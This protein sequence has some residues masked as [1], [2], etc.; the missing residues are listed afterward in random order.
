VD[1]MSTNVSRK[2]LRAMI[3]QRLKPRMK[4]ATVELSNSIVKKLGIGEIERTD[5]K[6]SEAIKKEREKRRRKREIL[7]KTIIDI[8]N[9]EPDIEKTVKEKVA[10]KTKYG[11]HY[12]TLSAWYRP[13]KKKKGIETKPSIQHAGGRQLT[14]KL[15]EKVIRPWLKQL[16]DVGIGGVYFSGSR[17]PF[18]G[19]SK[20]PVESTALFEEFRNYVCEKPDPFE[21]LETFRQKAGEL[22]SKRRDLSIAIGKLL[23]LSGFSPSF[24]EKVLECTILWAAGDRGHDWLDFSSPHVPPDKVHERNVSLRATVQ[25]PPY[26]TKASEILSMAKELESLREEMRTA[27][28]NHL[29]RAEPFS[30]RK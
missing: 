19:N 4:A 28:N 14:E 15:K 3:L 6:E 13:P 29:Y 24:R 20:L 9:K 10:I 11:V 26:S 23:E 17:T 22:W 30:R 5:E 18:D 2:T 12:Q 16:P 21:V 25:N 27:L 8:L 7:R 1:T